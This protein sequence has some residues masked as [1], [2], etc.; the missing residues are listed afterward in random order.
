MNGYFRVTVCYNIQHLR[1]G[2]PQNESEEHQRTRVVGFVELTQ[3]AICVERPW[4]LVSL[5]VRERSRLGR[6]V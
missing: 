1:K 2:A 5:R 4:S 3:N 6:G